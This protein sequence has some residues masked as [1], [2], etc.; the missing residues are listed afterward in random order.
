MALAEGHPLTRSTIREL[1]ESDGLCVCAEVDSA[2]PLLALAL[3]ERPQVCLIDL[4]LEHSLR[5]IS[6][7]VRNL[8]QQTIIAMCAQHSDEQ[9]LDALRSGASGYLLKDMDPTSLPRAIRAAI[10]GETA[11]PRGLVSRVVEDLQRRAG[12]QVLASDGTAVMLTIREA[13][14][15]DLLV[16]SRSTEQIA[17][18]LGVS[19]VTVRRHV[20]STVHKLHV[21][22]RQSAIRMLRQAL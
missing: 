19:S 14:V 3:R 11:L 20:S 6:L 4:E 18:Q 2:E 5:T 12:R 22:D 16:A 10:G 13:Q 15:V 7:I 8:P 1:L 17:E 21:P 9:M